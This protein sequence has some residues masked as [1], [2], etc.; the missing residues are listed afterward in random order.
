MLGKSK[1]DIFYQKV[2][3][4]S[5]IIVNTM[6]N[7]TDIYDFPYPLSSDQVNV[8]EDIK[9]LADRIEFILPS[10][11]VPYNSI[12]VT[13]I[14]GVSIA[15]GDPV[16]VTGFSGKTTVAKCDADDSNTFPVFGLAEMAMAD[17]TDGVVILSG[18]FSDIN[19]SSYTAGD[20]LY[21]SSSGG[22]TATQPATGSGAVA[23]V[24]KSGSSGIIVVGQPKGNGT[25]GSLKA[26][27]A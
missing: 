2:I 27:L 5:G 23:I 22:L 1:L 21:V 15:K 16:Y 18:V 9:S 7:Y 10:I 13:N 17:H 26:G 14:S 19:T 25:W 24:A 12:E 4:G 6:P 20:V 11:G 8:H 3:N